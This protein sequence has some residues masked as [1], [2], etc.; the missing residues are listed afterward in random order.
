MSRPLKAKCSVKFLGVD[1]RIAGTDGFGITAEEAIDL[2][3]SLTKNMKRIKK[4]ARL[5]K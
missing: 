4:S 2:H 5:W 1:I 3:R